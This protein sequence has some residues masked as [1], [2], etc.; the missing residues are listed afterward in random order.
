LIHKNKIFNKDESSIDFI[1]DNDRIIIIEP[2]YFPDEPYYNFLM[3][4]SSK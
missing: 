4:K 2:R 1:S 3:E